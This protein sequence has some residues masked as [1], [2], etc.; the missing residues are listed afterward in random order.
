[1]ILEGCGS[2]YNCQQ[3]TSVAEALYSV[4]VLVSFDNNEEGEDRVQKS[5]CLLSQANVS[6]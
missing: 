5:E 1:M 2:L 6:C 3:L 4:D